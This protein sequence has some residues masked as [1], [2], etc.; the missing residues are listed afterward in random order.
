LPN[1]TRSWPQEDFGPVLVLY[2]PSERREVCWV[3]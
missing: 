1:A 2:S 3:D